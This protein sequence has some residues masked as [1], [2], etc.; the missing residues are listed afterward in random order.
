VVSFI[1]VVGIRIYPVRE[2]K[3]GSGF[4]MC[5]INIYIWDISKRE[6]GTGMESSKF[7]APIKSRAIN[8]WGMMVSG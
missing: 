8:L 6:L 1:L 5:L 7:L 3:M 4:S 2:K